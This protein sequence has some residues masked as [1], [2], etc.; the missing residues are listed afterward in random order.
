[1]VNNAGINEDLTAQDHQIGF[2][3]FSQANTDRVRLLKI[4]PKTRI[5]FQ[6]FTADACTQVEITAHLLQAMD[7]MGIKMAT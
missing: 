3:R 1:V 7:R 2:N 6:D 4:N 5:T